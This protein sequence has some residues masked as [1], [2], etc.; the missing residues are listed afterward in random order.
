MS[1]EIEKCEGWGRIGRVFGKNG[2][3]TP[4]IVLLRFFDQDSFLSQ[5]FLPKSLKC[6]ENLIPSVL[7]KEIKSEKDSL[8]LQL[9]PKLFI[10]PSLQMQGKSLND[11]SC[12]EDLFPI[13]ITKN[14]DSIASYHIIPWDLPI[15][16]LGQYN[17]YLKVLNDINEPELS[18][19]T[20]LALNVPLMP[21]IFTQLLPILK[22]S[23]IEMVCLGD[24]SSLI[25]HPTLLLKFLLHIN[26]WVSPNIMLYAP[27]VPSSYIPIL[28]YLGIDL[29]DLLFVEMSSVSKKRSDL[30]FEQNITVEFFLERLWLTKK[31]LETGKLRDLS[32]IFA[33]SFPPLKTLLRVADSQI[34]LENNTPLYGPNTLFCTDETDFTRPEVTRFRKRV[35]TRYTP[36]KHIRGIIFLPCSAKK[37]YSK[38]KSHSLFRRV[39]KRN[40]KRKYHLI[41]EVILTSPLGVV[42]RNL[43]YTFPAGHYD[44]PVTGKWSEIEKK[45]LITDITY[46]IDKLSP[47]IPMVGYVTGKERE[48]LIEACSRSDRPIHL[49]S[50]EDG[51]LTSREN[52]QEFSRLLQDTFS[53]VPSKPKI[54][55]QLTFLR[56]VADYQFG[57]GIGSILIPN[58]VQIYGR[59]DFGFRVQLENKHLLTFRPK[60]GLL[61]LSLEAGERLSG[62]TSNT[63]TFD[64]DNI[65]GSTIFT[66]AIIKANE[67][68]CPNDEVLVVSTT[69]ELLAVGT[70]Y[71]SGDL[72]VKMKRG[73]GIKIRQKVRRK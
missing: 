2:F 6:Q 55:A 36:P 54:S 51:S 27:G 64:G 31:A 35:Q 16:N 57:K 17:S 62:Y 63:V 5:N 8:S 25:T 43:E 29:F 68:I 33:N 47:N 7:E 21:E 60:T 28:V 41:E 52:L 32:R 46:F 4:N 22:D 14:S 3:I 71:I 67:E 45:H 9:S 53:S 15:I 23:T 13:D 70:S 1:L 40:M 66:N 56:T 50:E 37:P 42:P 34:P 30:I 48:I 49:L 11:I 26:S 59:K 72:L 44:I 69:D 19:N 58:N 73:K 65:E 18:N 39:I 61:T 12:F 24:M 10:Y 38:S 20:K